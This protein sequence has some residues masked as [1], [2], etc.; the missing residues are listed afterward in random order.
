MHQSIFRSHEIPIAEELMALREDLTREFLNYH[1]DFL[2]GEFKKGMPVRTVYNVDSIVTYR[3]AWKATGIK[4]VFKDMS[5]LLE[6]G[7]RKFFP[8]AIKLTNKYGGDCPISSYSILES[9]SVIGRHTGPENRD[10]KYI[11][12]HI[13]LIVPE[14][15][16]FFEV[17][18]EVIT[19]ADLFGFDNQTVHS[20]HNYSPKRR[21]V[22][23]IDIARSRIGLP[24]GRP[25]DRERDE[26]SHPPFD[27]TPYRTA[28]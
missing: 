7:A 14:G 12:I 3:G 2:D 9:N 23:L 4:Y 17:G 19:W 13:P 8:T 6:V 24:P 20:A 21:L 10:G 22:F 26:F 27:P 18:G 25:Y 11:R 16:I 28:A 5:N 1:Q 15:D